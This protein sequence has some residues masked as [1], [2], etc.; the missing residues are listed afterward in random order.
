MFKRLKWKFQQ[1]I[2]ATITDWVVIGGRC[3]CCG[4]WVDNC[5]VPVYWR[6]TICDDCAKAENED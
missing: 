4:K 2:I 1:W 6:V 5:L 3:G